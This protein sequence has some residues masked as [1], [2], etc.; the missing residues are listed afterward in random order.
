MYAGTM[1]LMSFVLYSLGVTVTWESVTI[2][3]DNLATSLQAT[4]LSTSEGKTMAE[5]TVV[6]DKLRNEQKVE[7]I[8]GEAVKLQKELGKWFFAPFGQE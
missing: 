3:N 8:Y 6:S 5:T 1:Q 4:R 7:E 2:V